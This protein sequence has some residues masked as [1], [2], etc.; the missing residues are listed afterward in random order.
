MAHGPPTA[1]PNRVSLREALRGAFEHTPRTLALVWRSSPAGTLAIAALTL[2]SA[3]LPLG[4]AYA[5]KRIVDAVVAHD[6]HAAG[7]WVG[8]ELALVAALA[9]AA[10]GL[11]LVRQVAGARLGLD[12]NVAILEKAVRLELT[13]FED[14]DFYD[15]LTRARREASMRPLSVVSRGFTLVQSLITLFGYAALLFRFSGWVVGGL[16]L[17]SVPATVAELRFSGQLFR[18]RNWRSPDSRKLLY[19]EYV[20]A[21]D[22][23]AKEVKLFG[24]GPVLLD[25]YKTLGES[26]YREDRVLSVKRARWAYALSLIATGTFY[27]CYLAMAFAAVR[28]HLSLGDLTLDMIA[29]RQGQQSFQSLLGSFSGIVEDN[30]YMSNLFAYLSSGAGAPLL[31]S[32]TVHSPAEPIVG[33]ATNGVTHAGVESAAIV[34]EERGIHFVDAGFRYPGREEWALR[35]VTLFIHPGQSLALVGPNGAGKTTFIKLLTR[36]YVASEGRVLLDGRDVLDWDEK[37]L[38]Q[39]IAVV[40][41]DFAQYQFT[42]GENVGVGAVDHWTEEPQILRAVRSGG[43][44]EVVAGLKQGLSTPLGR[45]FR[46]GVE[47]STG[48]WQKIALARAFMR[49]GADILV[50]DEPTASLDA[51]SEHAVFDRFRELTRGKTS[52]II[53]HRFPTVRMA[54]R[55]LVLEGGHVIEDGT[56]AELLVKN[57]RYARFFELQAKA[58]E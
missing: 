19:L 8:T 26:F 34:G 56:H 21:S 33:A 58:Y 44:D 49:E 30:L 32:E 23:H 10:Q 7:R 25:R 37:A 11:A 1:S 18:L 51:E 29:F 5:G 55:I 43:A 38:H 42:A 6:V 24:L 53:S 39:R 57:G 27:G 36:L 45:W 9:A 47:L 22:E 17:A 14:A 52:I 20:L 54:D 4:V 2:V 50:L 31:A 35:H 13:D 40:F 48:Q 28:G 16:L 46:D 41:Q 15:R 12:V 3:V